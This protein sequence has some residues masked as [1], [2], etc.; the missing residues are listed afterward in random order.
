[1]VTEEW[2]GENKRVHV[3]ST[4]DKY[5]KKETIKQRGWDISGVILE[6]LCG[7]LHDRKGALEK[8]CRQREQLQ[9]P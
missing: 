1:M 2:E 6:G 4:R 7:D 3:V 9:R 8:S 5:V